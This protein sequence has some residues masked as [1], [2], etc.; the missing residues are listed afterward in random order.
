MSLFK[1]LYILLKFNKTAKVVVEEVEK[2][3]DVKKKSG[4]NSTEFYFTVLTSLGAVLASIQG[5]LP[6]LYASIVV[7]VSTAFY[8]LA[9][10]TVKQTSPNGG[11]KPG[12]KTTELYV[13]LFSDLGNILAAS[14]G[15][16]KPEVAAILVTI[17]RVA[18]SISRSLA[19]QEV[20]P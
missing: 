1:K 20:K 7:S 17:S 3:Q 4:I 9:R 19:K 11:D 6:P 13:G 15:V 16:V 2:V 18:Y 5:I 8:T 12:Y 10:G 14:T